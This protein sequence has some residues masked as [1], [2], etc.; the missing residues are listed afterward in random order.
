MSAANKLKESHPIEDIKAAVQKNI[1]EPRQVKRREGALV[2]RNA[3]AGRMFVIPFTIG[4]LT[5]FLY[6]LILSLIYSFS[7][8]TFGGGQLSV[9]FGT[10]SHYIQ[11]FTKDT[12]YVQNLLTTL[13]NMAVNTPVIIIF[14]I[15]ISII[16][17][18]KF[19]GRLLARAVFFLPVIV[20]SGVIISILKEDIFNQTVQLGGQQSSSIFQSS[21]LMDMMI[22]IKI[23][24]DI[25]N[26]F[27]NTVSQIFDMLWRTGVQ[28]LIFLAALQSI[29]GHLYEAA[30]IEGATGWESFWKITFP[31][32]SPM[33]MVNLT[34][35]IIDTFTDYTNPLMTQIKNEA[36]TQWHYSYS[37]AISWIFFILVFIIIGVVNL[38][39]S[40]FVF[41]Y[42]D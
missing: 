24:R 27:T 12:T 14:S 15:F 37:T 5:L 23:P 1:K 33:I 29:P 22:A 34:Y 38:I 9:K 3:M 16:L 32:I 17:N 30:K 41:Y 25:I 2:R 11:A 28:I 35:T 31:M 36:F 7:D 21:G 18:Q 26:G 20:T 4:F 39:L 6:P 13:Y 19:K 40:K 8:V 42:A 10:F